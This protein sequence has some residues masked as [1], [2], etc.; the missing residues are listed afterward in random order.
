MIRIERWRQSIYT[1]L[2]IAFFMIILP[3]QA[4]QL[5]MYRWGRN[6]VSRELYS[7]ASANVVYLRDNFVT[8][9]EFINVQME[10]L[11]SNYTITSFYVNHDH[12]STWKYY[13]NVAQ[14]NKLLY[15]IRSSNPFIE[16]IILYYPFFHIALSSELKI[17]SLDTAAMEEIVSNFR[18]QQSFFMEYD[19]RI[20]VGYMSPSTAYFSDELPKYFILA[21]L[22]QD[23]VKTHLSSFSQYSNKNAFFLNH[24]TG[25]ILAS[26]ENIVD[27]TADV[28]PLLSFVT[29]RKSTEVYSS[30]V[31][32]DGQPYIC[33]AC[34]S[35]RIHCSFIQLIPSY[36]LETIPN[37]FGLFIAAFSVLAVLVIAAYS[38]IMYRL[39]KRP[40]NDLISAF[41]VTGEGDFGHHLTP[42]YSTY[43]YNQLVLHFNAMTDRIKA[44]VQTNYEQTMRL[45]HA[46]L[47]QLQAQINPHF[48]YNS[49]FFLRHMIGG[50]NGQQ[51][52]AFTS[53]LG[54]YFQYITKNDTDMVPLYMEY[55]HALNYLTIQRMR[56]ESSMCAQVEA[57][58]S[59]LRRL[60][61]PRLILQPL[62]E[63]V[64]EHGIRKD[65]QKSIVRMRFEREKN[66][67][68]HVVIEDNGDQLTDAMLT[69]LQRDLGADAP[70]NETSGLINI[71]K[72]LE[73]YFGE[74]SGLT[75]MR[76]EL[77]GLR[78][79]IVV[80]PPGIRE[81]CNEIIPAVGRG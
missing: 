39:V 41:S 20:M 62:L 15:L 3:L 1:K 24:N 72:R 61:V 77:G 13:M 44:L 79:D 59:E 7:A 19:D 57:L 49:L 55:E 35:P 81:D 68:L 14:I 69:R 38:Q 12:L 26:S 48:L 11:L 50:G 51:A 18:R 37:R 27:D 64:L 40:M 52:K 28:S 47:K 10:Y 8:N 70:I 63:N 74:K 6:A 2:F 17:E 58:P 34:Y 75:V 78:V 4:T 33:V 9:I 29:P 21:V 25:S 53:Y 23:A 45:Q 22:S 54:K 65:G 67:L 16:N 43:E 73:L 56:F 76:S 5:A 66:C 46:E 36:A 71:H 30:P 32:I 42:R 80:H 31:E 60:Y